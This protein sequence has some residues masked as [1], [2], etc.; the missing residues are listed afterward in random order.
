M[1]KRQKERNKQQTEDG[2]KTTLSMKKMRMSPNVSELIID[3]QLKKKVSEMQ[4]RSHQGE[5][6]F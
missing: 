3:K 4:K 1:H 6:L 2:H 5:A